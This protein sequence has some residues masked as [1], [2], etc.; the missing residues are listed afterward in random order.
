MKLYKVFFGSLIASLVCGAFLF[1]G[2]PFLWDFIGGEEHI[3]FINSEVLPV[4]LILYIMY[5]I[6]QL[7]LS[8]INFI[9]VTYMDRRG[10]LYVDESKLF[11]RLVLAEL[12]LYTVVFLIFGILIR[13]PEGISFILLFSIPYVICCTNSILLFRFLLKKFH[14]E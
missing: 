4:F 3:S 2:I 13:N 14:P 11:S 8:V 5:A 1:I 12:C 10:I 9:Q 7:L 6:I